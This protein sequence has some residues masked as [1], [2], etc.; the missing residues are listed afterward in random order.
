MNKEPEL[1]DEREENSF[2]EK[3]MAIRV[4]GFAVFVFGTMYYLHKYMNEK[5]RKRKLRLEGKEEPLTEDE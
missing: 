1:E 3:G 2:E 5:L 4:L